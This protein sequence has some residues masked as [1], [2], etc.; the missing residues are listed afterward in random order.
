MQDPLDEGRLET[1][2]DGGSDAGSFVLESPAPPR[3]KSIRP[4]CNVED[5]VIPVTA[6]LGCLSDNEEASF[7][8]EATT[9]IVVNNGVQAVHTGDLDTAPIGLG[10]LVVLIHN[11]PTVAGSLQDVGLLSKPAQNL[12]NNLETSI[13][14]ASLTPVAVVKH[15]KTSGVVFN[16]INTSQLKSRRTLLQGKLSLREVKRMARLKAEK[17]RGL[18]LIKGKKLTRSSLVG[19][20]GTST[21]SRSPPSGDSASSHLNDY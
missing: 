12:E 10:P 20:S 18:V 1:G 21:M 8:R 19:V 4:I 13:P 15:K 9:E 7:C 6:I 14:D 17:E 2:S 3:S 11:G 5:R 16:L